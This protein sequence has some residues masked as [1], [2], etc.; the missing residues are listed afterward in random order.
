MTDDSE[1][2]ADNPPRRLYVYNGGFLTQRRTRRILE[3]AGYH[4]RLGKPGPGDMVGV[5]GQSP[6]SPRGEA[7]AARTEAPILRVEDAFLRSVRPGRSGDPAIG[8][9]LDRSGVHF[10]AEHVSD[11]ERLLAEAPLDDTALLNRARDGIERLR[12]AHLSKYNAF[13]AAA[14][15]PEPG[16]VLVIDQTKGDASVK[17]SRA[18]LNTF[19][20]MLFLA[21][22][23]HPGTRILIKTHPETSAGHRGG[24]FDD[25]MLDDRTTLHDAPVSP[26]RLLEGAIAVY[27]VSSQLGFEA[28]LAGHRP[29][30]MGRPFYMGWSLTDDRN[31][32]DRRQR[33]LTRAQLFAAA[34]ILYPTWY[35]PYRD[36][37]CDFETAVAT[38][39]AEA[40]AWRDDHRGWVGAGMRL[41]KRKPLQQVFG[42][43][44][45]MR[46]AEGAGAVARAGKDG[47]RLMVWAG[48]TTSELIAAGAVRVEDGFLRSR[49]LGAE[50]TPPLSLVLDDLGIYYDPSRES[51]LERLIN[52]S[53][54]LP[55]ADI[56]RAEALVEEAASGLMTRL[57]AD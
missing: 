40:R 9:L 17:A 1:A 33:R 34:M 43:H 20:E 39:E 27:T 45:K 3:L 18:D 47:R 14:P 42:L 31:P 16:Y 49:G 51:R 37:L 36:R 22:E 52:A 53:D 21:R 19:R 50:L 29:V 28:I 38:L 35:D 44:R 56:R 15:A 12:A 25:T 11:L 54:T 13:D 41:W 8:L 5:W 30:V 46:F 6:T 10:D 57:R 2:A 23:E 26:H 4:I 32:L 48:K 55:E 7:V 24:Y